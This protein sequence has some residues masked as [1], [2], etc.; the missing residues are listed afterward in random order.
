MLDE[1][2]VRDVLVIGG[3]VNGAGIARDAS[4]RG[5]SVMLCEKGD[6]ACGT[7][8]ASTKLFHGGLRYLEQYAF[9]LVRKALKEREILLANMPHIAH[10]MRFLLPHVRGM[11]PAWLLRL[12]LFIYDH[13]VW[14]RHLPPTRSVDLRRHIAGKPLKPHLVKAFEYSD[15]WVDDA[16]LVVLNAV[17]AAERGAEI[18]TRTRVVA[19]R[20]ESGLWRIEL[21]DEYTGR[22][23]HIRAR[24][25]VN[26]A[27][28]WVN[29]VA[30]G[31]IGMGAHDPIRLVR[32]SH[33]VVARLFDHDRAYF[34][35]NADGR[36]IFAL[37][38][39][40]DFTL[41]GTTDADHGQSPDLVNCS[42]AEIDYLC[43][44]AS[45]YFSTPVKPQDVIWTY[46]GVR[47]LDDTGGGSA[48]DASRDYHIRLTDE[49][50]RAPLVTIYGGKITTFRRL[51]EQVV[52]ELARYLELQGHAWTDHTPLPGGDFAINDRSAMVSRLT[53]DYPFLS[54]RDARRMLAAYGT[55]AWQMLGDARNPGDLGRS[56]G[57]GLTEVEVRWMMTR[58][59]ARTAE[60]V[61]WRRSKC[62]LR[63][64]GA[65]IAALDAWMKGVADENLAGD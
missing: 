2:K 54:P 13:L 34:F 52:A 60:D 37:P 7:S 64:T 49:G 24:A 30:E 6:L 32:G 44:A 31:V 15:G 63:L 10:P 19:A 39:E 17:D 43:N 9:G 29:L 51:A 1:E 12:G 35:Q 23:R 50:G 38:Y 20:R 27:G 55:R 58:E 40:E 3:G 36:I 14:N 53:G 46:A 61:V 21:I 56:F 28:P 25:L 45:E 26:A 5:L 65:E 59:W 42:K 4:G 62:G 47:P 16:R 8:S 22:H 57:A 18:L 33:I 41:I 48:S 11:R